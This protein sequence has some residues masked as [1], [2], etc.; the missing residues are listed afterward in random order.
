SD[1]NPSNAAGVLFTTV[2]RTKLPERFTSSLKTDE[3]FIH[4]PYTFAELL[5]VC[6]KLARQSVARAGGT[7]EQTDDGDVF[8]V[9]VEPARPG[10]LEQS[11]EP[12]PI[13]ESRFTD[14]EVRLITEEPDDKP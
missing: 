11:W 12:G 14:A 2:G 9:P 13:A 7:I 4:T 3:K 8:V 1:C 5:D 6:E 10:K